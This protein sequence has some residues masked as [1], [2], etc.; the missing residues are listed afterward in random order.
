[1]IDL[2]RRATD[3]E[4]LDI[5]VPEEEA[6]RSLGDL[7]FVNRWLG[8]RGRLRAVVYEQLAGLAHPRL[9]DVGCGS[10]DVSAD[11][12]AASPVPLR[13]VGV[14]LKLLHVRQVPESVVPVVANARALPF[15][16]RSLTSWWFRCSS[17][18]STSPSCRDCCGIS[19]G[20]AG[21]RSWSLTST[22]PRAVSVRPPALPRPVPLA[23]ER[24]G[25]PALHPPRVPS[26]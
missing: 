13:A 24:R 23:G 21:A 1:V 4:S 11:L 8:A 3:P 16:P 7:R 25:R 19:T 20:S 22:G 14:D 6:L 9:L 5:G 18:T 2:A 10:G 26:P 15:G 17:I 12:A